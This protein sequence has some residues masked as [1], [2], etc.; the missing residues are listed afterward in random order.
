MLKGIQLYNPD[1]AIKCSE[2]NHFSEVYAIMRA[3]G[4]TKSY[5]YGMC[6]Q[7]G[8]LTFDFLKCGM[9]CPS[10]EEK[11]G[12]QVGERITRQLAWVPGWQGTHVHSNNGAD[13]W[14]GIQHFMMVPNGNIPTT[15]NKNELTVAVWDVSSRMKLADISDHDEYRAT[16]WAEGELV[17]QY[18]QRFGKKPSLNIQDPSKSKYYTSGYTPKSVFNSLFG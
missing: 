8:P 7:P 18:K 14:F 16:A 5:V 6:Y 12:Y 15:F 1:F 9:S 2:L 17:A 3:N 11:R 4:I 13:F 10:L